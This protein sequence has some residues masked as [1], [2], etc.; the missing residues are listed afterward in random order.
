MFKLLLTLFMLSL[1][2]AC[3]SPI[4]NRSPINEPFPLIS[5]TNL[6]DENVELPNDLAGDLKLLLVGY[7]ERSQFD[8]DRWLIALDM[9]QTNVTAYEIP[10]IFGM[11]PQM[12]E[13]FIND[14]MRKG[15][16]KSLW[17]GVIT[18]FDDANKITQLTGTENPTNARVILLDEKGMI[19]Y[20]YDQGFAVDALND[21][22]DTINSLSSHPKSIT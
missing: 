1:I 17:G 4:Q 6:N 3:S 22:R 8:I 18:V 5:G 15:I 16:P 7:K 9:T 10:T 12:F 14:G 19:I 13:P 21:L 11:L 20:F 2:T